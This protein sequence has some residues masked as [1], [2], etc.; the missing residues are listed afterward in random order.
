MVGHIHFPT[1]QRRSVRIV[2]P[3]DVGQSVDHPNHPA[4]W[5]YFQEIN[6]QLKYI[7]TNIAHYLTRVLFA[8]AR[9]TGTQH[10]VRYHFVRV[11]RV[12]CA[13]GIGQNGHF[14]LLQNARRLAVLL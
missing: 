8:N 11:I 1:T 4:Q 5:K 2:C 7:I 14:D 10:I 12:L 3:P 9:V 6:I 13:Y